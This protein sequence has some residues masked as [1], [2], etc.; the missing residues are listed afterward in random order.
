VE[1]TRFPSVACSCGRFGGSL[2][3]S[4]SKNPNRSR[5]VAKVILKSE[6]SRSTGAAHSH[7]KLPLPEGAA[8]NRSAGCLL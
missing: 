7:G 3:A 8:T 5:A 6:G 4:Q 1:K 2:Q